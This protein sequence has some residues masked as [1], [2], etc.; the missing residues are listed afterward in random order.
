MD[1][2]FYVFGCTGLRMRGGM[3]EESVMGLLDGLIGGA[4]G[5]G[6]AVAAERIIAQHGGVQGVVNQMQSQGLGEA[7]R[8]WVSTGPNQPISAEHL[9]Q[10]FGSGTIE[11]IAQ[12]VGMTPADLSQRLAQFLPQAIDHLTPNGQVPPAS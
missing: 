7:V 1:A 10:V 12:R 3:L 2:G 9:H 5:A 11:E 4:V 8:S 6:L